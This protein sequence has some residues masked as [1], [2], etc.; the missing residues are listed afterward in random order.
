MADLVSIDEYNRMVAAQMSENALQDQIEALAFD[1]GWK[2]Y[3]THD[4]RRSDPGWPDLALVHPARGRFMV[5]ELKKQTGRV[6]KEQRE[7]LD[8]LTGAGV[9]AG[10]W[11]PIDYVTR[12]VERELTA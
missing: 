7:W 1:L 3:H 12:A 4:S 9:D 10:V 5:R 11:R 6:S 8:A 2:T